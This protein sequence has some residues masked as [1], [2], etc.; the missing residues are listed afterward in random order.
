MSETK[1]RAHCREEGEKRWSM[2]HFGCLSCS[3][4]LGIVGSSRH[5]SQ[6][7]LTAPHPPCR[8]VSPYACPFVGDGGLSDGFAGAWCAQRESSRSD[9]GR[10]GID[11]GES[12]RSEH[13]EGAETWTTKQWN[14]PCPVAHDEDATIR[15][16]GGTGI[17][18]NP[19]GR[20]PS[21]GPSPTTFR[22]VI[23]ACEKP[24]I[25]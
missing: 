8:L 13:D 20:R 15:A 7:L 1:S 18:S 11:R 21:G 17:L 6:S 25:Y 24:N 22:H 5:P 14:M 19:S 10:W 16:R 9:V 23:R 4:S 3:I 12:E 2:A